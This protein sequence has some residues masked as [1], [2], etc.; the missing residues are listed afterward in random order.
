MLEDDEEWE[1]IYR[2]NGTALGREWTP[3]TLTIMEAMDNKLLKVGDFPSFQTHIPVFSRR[4]LE[5][6]FPLLEGS[7]EIFPLKHALDEYFLFNVTKVVDVLEKHLSDI[8]YFS[9]GKIMEI[10]RH[11]FSDDG[12]HGI[13]IFKIP[14]EK[15]GRVFVSDTFRRHVVEN[16]LKGFMFEPI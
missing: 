9:D 11:A 3:F 14:E 5:V 12:L 8:K 13:H 4:A 7:G 1:Q 10:R 15:L 6:L 2:Y 16:D